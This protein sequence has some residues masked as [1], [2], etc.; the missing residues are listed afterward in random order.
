MDRLLESLNN[1]KD[2]HGYWR[3]FYKDAVLYQVI[4][5]FYTINLNSHVLF[6]CEV[7]EVY[8]YAEHQE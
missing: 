2:I 5:E 8:G 7:W 3:Q 6:N 4:Y 1:W